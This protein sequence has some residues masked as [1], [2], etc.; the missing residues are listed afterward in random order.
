MKVLVGIVGMGMLV[1]I[2]LLGAIAQLIVELFPLL[3]VVAV[4]VMVTAVLRRRSGPQRP[5][6]PAPP[7]FGVAVPPPPAWVCPPPPGWVMVPVWVGPAGSPTSRPYIDAEV[8]DD[9]GRSWR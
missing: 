4:A 3:V 9:G 1:V 8:T 7:R 2:V 6:L 5:P